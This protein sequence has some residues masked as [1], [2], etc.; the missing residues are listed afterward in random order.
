M[1]SSTCFP[2]AIPAERQRKIYGEDGKATA[3]RLG[4]VFS[5]KN[6]ASIFGEIFR[7]LMSEIL[8]IE[9]ELSLPWVFALSKHDSAMYQ[10][11]NCLPS[12]VTL[13]DGNVTDDETRCERPDL[14]LH[15]ASG[16][17]LTA[18]GR[19]DEWETFQSIQQSRLGGVI[20]VLGSAGFTTRDGV[21]VPK[22]LLDEA[23]EEDLIALDFYKSYH[24]NQ[25]YKEKIRSY[26][27]TMDEI[28][29]FGPLKCEELYILRKARPAL[30]CN[31]PLAKPMPNIP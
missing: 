29:A 26:F 23:F 16:V 1:A 21:A 10:L 17:Q 12:G 31:C 9:T 22:A 19:R 15:A 18:V 6:E 7:I 30:F 13:P 5:K 27:A 4:D 25:S 3:L 11:S 8:G 28:A 2:D 20:E 24:V 14:M